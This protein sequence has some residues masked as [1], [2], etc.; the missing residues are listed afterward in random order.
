P[1][2]RVGHAPQAAPVAGAPARPVGAALAAAPPAGGGPL[3]VNK[4]LEHRHRIT[5]RQRQR[6][7]KRG[8]HTASPQHNRCNYTTFITP[9]PPGRPT[10][11][12]GLPGVP[13]V[14]ATRPHLLPADTF[15]SAHD[16]GHARWS[17]G[18]PRPG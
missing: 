9:A 2:R 13:E 8:I 6:P 5:V 10:G 7:V 15:P 14:E 18:I 11:Q 12:P 17:P 16:S 1:S 4:S 3:T